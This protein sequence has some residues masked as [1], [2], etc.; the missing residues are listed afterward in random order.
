MNLKRKTIVLYLFVKA[1]GSALSATYVNVLQIIAFFCWVFHIH[2]NSTNTLLKGSLEMTRC[3]DHVSHKHLGNVL[4]FKKPVS[5]FR[6]E[7]NE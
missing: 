4:C 7:I 3:S 2:L 1:T 6:G 5:K